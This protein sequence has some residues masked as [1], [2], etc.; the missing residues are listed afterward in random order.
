MPNYGASRNRYYN[1]QGAPGR[2]TFNLLWSSMHGG[3]ESF[4]G[5]RS[6]RRHRN[7]FRYPAV[8]FTLISVN[9]GSYNNCSGSST[10]QVPVLPALH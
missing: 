5:S 2:G 10:K 9:C 1:M 6:M 3:E 7:D 8:S 4:F